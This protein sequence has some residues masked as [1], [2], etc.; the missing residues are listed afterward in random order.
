MYQRL[1]LGQQKF[2][3]VS[4]NFH[5]SAKSGHLNNGGISPLKNEFYFN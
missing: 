1:I 4:S 5:S 2:D 3:N